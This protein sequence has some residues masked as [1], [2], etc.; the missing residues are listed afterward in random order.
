MKGCRFLT[1]VMVGVAGTLA[2]VA[3]VYVGREVS[4]WVRWAQGHA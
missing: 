4:R 3:A 2:T 1:G